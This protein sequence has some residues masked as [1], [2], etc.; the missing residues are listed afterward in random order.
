MRSCRRYST[1]RSAFHEE[2][3]ARTAR[4]NCSRGS[5]GKSRPVC[6]PKMALY[7]LT[8]SR[9]FSAP[10]ST[11]VRAPASALASSNACSKASPGTPHTVLPYIWINRRYESHAKRSLPLCAASPTT[12]ESVNPTFSTVSIIPGMENFAPERTD[13]SSGSDGS[14]SRRPIRSS[15]AARCAATSSA[16]LSGS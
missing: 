1:A 13:T 10:N 16:R 9:S 14:P 4:S 15:S 3:T 6:S 2:N 11:S 7:L 12:L 5:C 8:S